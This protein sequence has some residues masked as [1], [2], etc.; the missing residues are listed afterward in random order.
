M[1]ATR[2]ALGVLAF[3][4]AFFVVKAAKWGLVYGVMTLL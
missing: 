4:A 1:H 2:L 3:L